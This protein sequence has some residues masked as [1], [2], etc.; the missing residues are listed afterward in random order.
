VDTFEK[1]PVALVTYWFAT[2]LPGFGRT[3]TGAGALKSWIAGA[4][5]RAEQPEN[6]RPATIKIIAATLNRDITLL[7]RR[8]NSDAEPR[9][10]TIAP[11][12]AFY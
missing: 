4:Y 12:A 5:G 6:A 9:Y 7:L 3:G 10:S 8:S 2:G 1:L 11:P